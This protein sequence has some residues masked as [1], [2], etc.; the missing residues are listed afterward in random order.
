MEGPM[1]LPTILIIIL[2]VIQSGCASTRMTFTPTEDL[3]ECRLSA[4]DL[5]AT[6]VKKADRSL[7]RNDIMVIGW[8]AEKESLGTCWGSDCDSSFPCPAVSAQKDVTREMAAKAASYGG[9]VLELT[10]DRELMKQPVSKPG[11]CRSGTA[12]DEQTG[13]PEPRSGPEEK[14]TEQEAVHG[15]ECAVVSAGTVWRYGNPEELTPLIRSCKFRSMK[16][17]YESNRGEAELRSRSEEKHGN[18]P[19]RI[20]VNGKYGFAVHDGGI[21]I[22]PQ[23]TDAKDSFSEDLGAV[24]LGEKDDKRW[25]FIDRTGKWVI[26]PAYND[27]DTFHEG[28][29]AVKMNDRYGYIDKRGKFIIKPQFDEAYLFSRGIAKVK[30]GRKEAFINKAGDIFTEP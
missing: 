2:L 16:K 5:P 15:R 1:N 17:A 30:F 23:F 28:L 11:K 9:D 18:R 7:N 24:S 20:K 6:V 22:E 21:I 3:R 14:C 4:R 25:G 26:R 19:F 12:R 10:A 13:A 27:A 29:A 8:I